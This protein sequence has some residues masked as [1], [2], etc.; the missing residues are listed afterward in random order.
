MYLNCE[1]NYK[2]WQFHRIIE[3]MTLA[4]LRRLHPYFNYQN[5]DYQ[6]TKDE[7]KLSF[8]FITAPN[9]QFQAKL[10]ISCQNKQQLSQNPQEKNHGQSH[11]PANK[12][13]TAFSSQIKNKINSQKAT[14]E[15]LIF[16]LGLAE[17]PS[18]WKATC[19]PTIT[20]QAGSLSKNQ[21]AW[22]QDLLINGL[23]EFFYTNQIDVNKKDFLNIISQEKKDHLQL[24]Y[25]T[26]QTLSSQLNNQLKTKIAHPQYLV[27]IGGGKDSALCLEILD[28]NHLPYSCLLLAPHSPA[29]R[30][31]AEQ[32][33]CQAIITVKRSIDQRLLD[34][35]KKGYL[36]GHTPFSSYLAFLSNLIAFL[37]DYQFVLVANERSA[38][39][40]NL[41]Y[42]S[43]MI[44]HQY[45]KSFDFEQKFHQYSQEYLAQNRYFSFFRPLYELQ[46]AQL[47]AA[48]PRYQSVFKSCNV[49]QQQAQWCHHCPKC[50][51]VFTLL[52]PFISEKIL[53][54]KIF[55][56]NLF[57]DST[58]VDQALALL[59]H[60]QNKPFEC[61]GTYEETL[62]AYYLAIVKITGQEGAE[63]LILQANSIQ[64]LPVVLQAVY[65]Q[66]IQ[67]EKNLAQRAK[68]ILTA[69]DDQH[70]LPAEFNTILKA[71][72]DQRI[73][74]EEVIQDIK[75]KNIAILG[76]GR[77]GLSTYQFI[78]Q[79]LP[80]KKLAVI[81]QQPADKFNPA[82]MKNLQLD[83]NLTLKLGEHYLDQID[84]YQ[85]IIKTPGIPA[86][87]PQIKKAISHGAKLSSNMQLFFTIFENYR[88][89]L[90]ANRQTKKS[91][92]E[93]KLPLIIGITGTKGKSTTAS[94][95]HHLLKTAHYQ[96][97]LVGN[98][99]QAA[100]SFI[101][102]VTAKSFLVTELSCHQLQSL[103][104]SPQIAVIQE[105]NPEHL[106]YYPD[107][108]SYIQAKTSIAKYQ[109]NQQ[110]KVIYN[111]ASVNTAKI[112][113]LSQ[114]QP[115]P[116]DFNQIKN[117]SLLYI[118]D[119][120]LIFNDTLLAKIQKPHQRIK[121]DIKNPKIIS[122]QQLTLLGKHNLNNI[123]PAIIIAKSLNIPNSIIEQALKT[124]QP[125]EHRLEKVA[126][127][128][129]V[130]YI[131]DSLATT[132]EA[133]INAIIS[134]PPGK[135]I[136]IAGGHERKQD[137][138]QLASI[139]KQYQVKAL[140][141]FP[142][143]GQRIEKAV[144]NF[145]VEIPIY[146][147]TQM[148][149]AV[150]KAKSLAQAQDVVLLSPAAA[151]YNLFK[152]YADR[153]QQFKKYILSTN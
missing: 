92:S 98:I 67:K 6:L 48:Y 86:D 15:S 65:Q 54:R 151:S 35:N 36:N 91:E 107:V 30:L 125:L 32:S 147:V 141:L 85:L 149:A 117:D 80:E 31:M 76:L 18:Y 55:Q 9:L 142:L 69:W 121:T 116:Y 37:F 127:I 152:D 2:L 10:G 100:L 63:R 103:N 132:P 50:L 73:A 79:Y 122:L 29:A 38:N 101:N 24:S 43:Y 49:G 128:K 126:T 119:D 3:T 22:W 62:I 88:N 95:I 75:K 118:K 138:Q 83:D 99:G 131:N 87:L 93:L 114:G 58:L 39:E 120:Y 68:K 115:Y 16:H 82:V 137:F 140:I 28:K 108:E 60:D 46:I 112:A 66:V 150:Q 129:K 145:Q 47:L 4:Q 19:S 12:K 26:D 56:K 41:Q 130:I 14:L 21:L 40:A 153:G 77:E 136:L 84:Q 17:I 96:S 90:L 34:L 53:T 97:F 33:Q 25:L 1:I 106:D 124:F 74:I 5:Y 59:G 135:V 109:N 81:D 13:A 20:I 123:A 102:Q 42:H 44:N 7:F 70:Y 57:H 61:V 11:Q 89:K 148:K 71:E 133:S 139:I 94:L 27:P 72:L 104:F 64:Q 144:K 78:R 105:V 146:H 8:N 51:F 134:F 113:S 45:S 52:Y 110:Y 111:N 143:T 23:G